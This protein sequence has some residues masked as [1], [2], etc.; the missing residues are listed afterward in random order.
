MFL[1][2][3]NIKTVKNIQTLKWIVIYLFENIR[4][5]VTY[6]LVNQT[7]YRMR[8]ID[9]RRRLCQDKSDLSTSPSETQDDEHISKAWSINVGDQVSLINSCSFEQKTLSSTLNVIAS[10]DCNQLWV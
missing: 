4:R 1:R 3:A 8:F 9:L 2:T 10:L 5:Y 6:F 7:Q